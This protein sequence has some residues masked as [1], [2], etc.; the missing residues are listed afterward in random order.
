MDF[1]RENRLSE[2]NPKNLGGV[3]V[4]PPPRGLPL[5]DGPL[6]IMWLAG[7][8]CWWIVPLYS[9]F[10]LDPC[11][12]SWYAI[13]FAV[14][15]GHS[16]P[17][18]N[19][20]TLLGSQWFVCLM[21]G[22]CATGGGSHGGGVFGPLGTM[23]PWGDSP[24]EGR[25]AHVAPPPCSVNY[26]WEL[27]DVCDRLSFFGSSGLLLMFS[28]VFL[29]GR[30]FLL[31]L[32]A[33]Q[34]PTCLWLLFAS[35]FFSFVWLVSSPPCSLFFSLPL[36]RW[37]NPNPLRGVWGSLCVSSPWTRS[38]TSTRTSSSSTSPQ[39]SPAP[40]FL[41]LFSF[42]LDAVARFAVRVFFSFVFLVCWR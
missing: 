29:R 21:F 33:L 2:T 3:L 39:P 28:F 16:G 1:C 40:V 17:A 30:C 25:G 24:R 42:S 20:T 23:V 18:K 38:A 7:I 35:L 22:Y 9:V 5:G 41:L 11:F 13:L 36:R 12:V 4:Q 8:M 26:L 27:V 31:V 6:A 19:W 34:A 32:W 10:F 14:L 15:F 37:G